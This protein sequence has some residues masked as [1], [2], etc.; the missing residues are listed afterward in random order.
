MSNPWDIPHSSPFDS[1]Q[2]AEQAD[3]AMDEGWQQW[4]DSQPATPNDD[5]VAYVIQRAG[6]VRPPYGLPERAAFDA[7]RKRS[8][9]NAT[10]E[11]R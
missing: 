7:E 8:P 1:H 11:N 2:L 9:I 4:L 10:E 5:L 6:H 3:R